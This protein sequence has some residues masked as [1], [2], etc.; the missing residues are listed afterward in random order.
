MFAYCENAPIATSDPFG[1]MA[2]GRSCF[3]NTA[4][5]SYKPSKPTIICTGLDN[6]LTETSE[7]K[8]EQLAKKKLIEQV[9]NDLRG[10]DNVTSITITATKI[11]HNYMY[12]RDNT[13]NVLSKIS[14][15]GGIAA[16]LG[17]KVSIISPAAGVAGWIVAGAGVIADIWADSVPASG[18]YNCYLITVS[19]T[20]ENAD[21]GITE[22]HSVS[23]FSS[24]ND[25]I[26]EWW[27]GQL[28]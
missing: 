6:E 23:F 19:W 27:S 21:F 12:T 18:K 3:S 26:E 9:Q 8:Y 16:G 7:G 28:P 20:C 25:G 11:L 1:T 22:H 15:Y 13:I 5:Y 10:T 17:G 14:T 4:D 24:W 2:G